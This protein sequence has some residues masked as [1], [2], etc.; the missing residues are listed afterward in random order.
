MEVNMKIL[1]AY[2]AAVNIAAFLVM[3]ADKHKA[4]RHERRISEK[5][6]FT[7]GFAGGSLGVLI[8][9]NIFHHKT[10]HLKFTIG[11]PLMLLLNIALLVYLM[12]TIL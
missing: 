3:G 12:N 2:I 1:W 7:L 4:K 11:I 8:G 10:K 9:M 6:I 5:S